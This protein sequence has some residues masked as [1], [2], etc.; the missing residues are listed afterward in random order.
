[1]L[2]TRIR[3]DP[4]PAGPLVLAATPTFALMA[5]LSSLGTPGAALCRGA[6]S[7]FPIDDMALMY[8]LMAIFHLSPWFR[9]RPSPARH[10]L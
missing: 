2:K 6:N 4:L 10:F 5:G 8:L 9:L 1:M 7:S 3:A